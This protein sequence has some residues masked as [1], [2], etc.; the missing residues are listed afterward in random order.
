MPSKSKT[1]GNKFENDVVKALNEAY[2]TT[3]FSRTPNSGAMMGRTN[4]GKNQGLAEGVKRTLGSD[5]IVPDDFKFSIECKHYG[6]APNY[7]QIIKGP[8]SKLDHWLAECT[9]DA[10]NLD[11]HPLLVFK[12]NRKGTYFALPDYFLLPLTHMLLYGP[13][14]ITGFETFIQ[15]ANDIKEQALHIEEDRK[16][17]YQRED[18]LEL[19]KILEEK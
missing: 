5:L 18:V 8:D 16:E 17:F 19:L 11:L 7:S 12:T 13:F 3:E 15:C 14:Q 6:D 9:F 2:N 4:W 1:K 10:D